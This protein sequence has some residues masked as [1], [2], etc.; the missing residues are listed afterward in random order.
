MHYRLDDEDGLPSNEVYQVLQDDFGFMWIACDAGLYRYDGFKFKGYTSK[1]QNSRSV[2]NLKKDSK[3]NIWCQNF[4]GQIFR[5]KNDSLVLFFDGS[6]ANSS[7]LSYEIDAQNKVWIINKGELNIFMN[8]GKI[9]SNSVNSK[10]NYWTNLQRHKNSIIATSVKNEFFSIDS[11]NFKTTKIDCSIEL[12]SKQKMSSF[13]NELYLLSE[14]N[15]ERLYYVSR[16]EKSKINLLNK[17]QPVVQG[18]F[19]YFFK[20]NTKNYFI[21]TSDGL[22]I[23]SKNNASFS[24]SKRYFKGLKISD[25]FEDKEGNLW[26]STLQDGIMVV[27]N[28]EIEYFDSQNSALNDRNI[29]YLTQ[30]KGEL[31]IGTYSGELFKQNTIT[32]ELSIFQNNQLSK[33]R[34]IRKILEHKGA[35][36]IACGPLRSI[37][38]SKFNE[39]PSLN[40]IRDMVI[41]DEKLYF[42][43]PERMGYLDLSKANIEIKVL[44]NN[45]GKK[46]VID[47]IRKRLFIAFVDGLFELKNNSLKELKNKDQSIFIADMVYGGNKLWIGT[48]TE[49]VLEFALSEKQLEFK[50][51]QQVVGKNTRSLL[52]ADNKLWVAN[53]N[54]LIHYDPKSAF[55]RLLNKC[56]GLEF[57]EVIDMEQ[58]DNFLYLATNKGLIKFPIQLRH[59]NANKPL[60][61]LTEIRLNNS[62]IRLSKTLELQA[63]QLN[64]TV[65]F[66]ST[67]LRSRGDFFYNYRIL[68]YDSKWKKQSSSVPFIS[69]NSLPTGNYILEIRS[70]NENG[71][72]SKTIR[73]YLK[74]IAPFYERWWFYLLLS[75]LIATIIAF[76]FVLR[77]RFVKKQALI[78]NKLI[79]SQLTA[80]KSQMNPHFM[81]NTLSSIQDFIW[82]NDLKNSNYFL[83][84]FSMLMR[85]ILEASDKEKITLSEEIELL[86]LYLELEKLRFGANFSF[87]IKLDSQ[88]DS[89][90]VLIPAMMI[91]PFVENAIKHGLLHK[92]GDKK[93]IIEFK[94][95]QSKIKCIVNDNGIGRVKA[96]EIKARQLAQHTSFATKATQKRI[97]LLSAYNA[98][99]YSFSIIDLFNAA[100]EATGTQVEITLPLV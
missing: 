65:F 60:L 2:S 3:G 24:L 61:K 95:F 62:F 22:I 63:N 25:F 13:K 15:P 35:F 83:S 36:Y 4:T 31:L 19:H 90:A 84:K 89:D 20:A 100:G 56:D 11:K 8:N 45:G 1:N 38:N 64:L 9:F 54:G 82:Q 42:I 17:M 21:G 81:Y 52:F 29:Y 5:V 37:G 39:I 28:K 12:G 40:N 78:Q 75:T 92:T 7:F 88:L 6:K 51:V 76:V 85:K 27:A 53:E 14:K 41:L 46:I 68:N 16:I 70:V 57:F 30:D 94:L 32:N 33:F 50:N 96:S 91:Q 80:L 69:V 10:S 44:R 67:A 55:T 87:E 59:F 71:I 74:V 18:G 58:V 48:M 79:S 73:L 86:T 66:I 72:S 43:T 98:S 97:E 47:P 93:L 77:I 34:A 49:G 99:N 26:I 23:S